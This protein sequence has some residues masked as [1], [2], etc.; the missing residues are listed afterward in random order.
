MSAFDPKRTLVIAIP[1]EILHR[2]MKLLP[3]LKARE[4]VSKMS[5]VDS[6]YSKTK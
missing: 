5:T 6:G 4:L 2:N 3:A 1:G